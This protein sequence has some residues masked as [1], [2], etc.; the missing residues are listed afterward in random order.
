MICYS[1]ES[2]PM[3]RAYAIVIEQAQLNYDW[4]II[5][6][7]RNN[8][9]SKF[10][11]SAKKNFYEQLPFLPLHVFLKKDF[12]FQ[13]VQ[14]FQT[15]SLDEIES[16]YKNNV[17]RQFIM[18][19]NRQGGL[20]NDTIPCLISTQIIWIPSE[21]KTQRIMTNDERLYLNIILLYHG[22]WKNTLTKKKQWYLK[23]IDGNDKENVNIEIIFD[24]DK[25]RRNKI[26]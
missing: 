16:N 26:V 25:S 19:T 6:R 5:R 4:N 14:I 7:G 20:V 18:V 9:L 12:N 24:N 2:S 1:D 10:L 23:E 22:L 11:P 3:Y 15:S 8:D 21:T 17:A 13:F